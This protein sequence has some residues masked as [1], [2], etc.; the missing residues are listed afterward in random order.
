[1]A[2]HNHD[3][4]T[5]AA[6]AIILTAILAVL[7]AGC[8]PKVQY[9]P[10]ERIVS[11]TDTVQSATIR[12]DSVIFRDSV[13]LMQ[14]GDTVYLTK[15]RDRYRVRERVDTLYQSVTDS[16]SVP[17][18]YPVER[19]LTRW[20]RTK[21]DYGGAAIIL[22]LVLLIAAGARLIAGMRL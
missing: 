5:S 8:S 20:E 19:E 4:G 3:R 13:T 16:V 21:L 17:V 9:I 2:K 10:Q 14:R 15:Y 11:R 22:L 12:V 6:S 1:M 18:P 7:L